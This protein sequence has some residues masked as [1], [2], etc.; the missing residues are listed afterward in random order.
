MGMKLP[1]GKF[2]RDGRQSLFYFCMSIV[3]CGFV[4]TLNIY[5]MVGAGGCSGMNYTI[6]KPFAGWSY[7]GAVLSI[8]AL[9]IVLGTIMIWRAPW[10]MLSVMAVL[11]CICIGANTVL[12]KGTA[13][14][15]H[16]LEIE[17]LRLM[18]ETGHELMQ[19]D[20]NQEYYRGIVRMWGEVER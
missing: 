19:Y 15:G 9:L 5:M 1:I 18:D 17:H 8:I 3:F 13:K 11:A 2:Q 14:V 6:S 10:K 20:Y 4:R 12:M 16:R 7:Y